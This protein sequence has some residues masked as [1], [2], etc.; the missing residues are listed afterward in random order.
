MTKS[1]L[2]KWS[3]AR[4]ALNFMCIGQLPGLAWLLDL[5]LLIMHFNYA[6]PAAIFTILEMIPVVGFFPFFTV[7]AMLYPNHDEPSATTVTRIGPSHDL[8]SQSHPPSPPLYAL[9]DGRLVPVIMPDGS[10]TT[11]AA[12]GVRQI[13]SRDVSEPR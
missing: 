3:V 10:D 6:G 7:A 1:H 13:E 4:D 5:P 12:R 8:V 11:L 9:V 2:I